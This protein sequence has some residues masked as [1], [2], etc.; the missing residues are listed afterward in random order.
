MNLLSANFAS[1]TLKQYVNETKENLKSVVSRR[2]MNK[3]EVKPQTYCHMQQL[4]EFAAE[5]QHSRLSGRVVFELIQP[6]IPMP[7]TVLDSYFSRL[8]FRIEAEELN[9]DTACFVQQFADL[10]ALPSIVEI[11]PLANSVTIIFTF[12]NVLAE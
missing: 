5:L 3:C 8:S 6:P 11:R 12:D 1:Q 9:I 7:V 10:V 4:A 2:M